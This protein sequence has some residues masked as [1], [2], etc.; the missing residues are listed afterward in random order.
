MKQLKENILA[1]LQ[2]IKGSGKFVSIRTGDFV[3]RGVEVKGLGE[4]AFPVNKLQAKALIE[5]AHK[6]PFGKS[7]QT[8]IDENVRSGWEID[9]DNLQFNN[10][11]WKKFLGKA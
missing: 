9:A 1:C 10:P 3:F 4:I 7:S 2:D 11:N 8:I 6:A 5:V